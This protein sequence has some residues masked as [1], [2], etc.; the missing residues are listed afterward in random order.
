M[1]REDELSVD[2]MGLRNFVWVGYVFVG[3]VS[4]MEKL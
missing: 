3:M 2:V 1:S 4:F